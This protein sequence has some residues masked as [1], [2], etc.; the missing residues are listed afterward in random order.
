[1]KLVL[2]YAILTIVAVGFV[3][4]V[5]AELTAEIE[6]YSINKTV[7]IPH[8]VIDEACETFLDGFQPLTQCYFAG[9]LYNSTEFLPNLVWDHV[10]EEYKTPEQLE[11]EAREIYE[12]GDYSITLED[13]ANGF[14][15]YVE[16]LSAS[17]SELERLINNMLGAK[18]HQ[19]IGTTNGIQNVRSFDIPTITI[20][21]YEEIDGEMVDTGRTRE[22]LDTTRTIKDVNLRSVLGELIKD[23]RECAAQTILLDPHGGVLSITDLNFGYCDS[24]DIEDTTQLAVCGK[25]YSHATNA[26]NVPVWS[27]A[28]VNEESNPDTLDQPSYN[29]D[30]IC[31]GYYSLSYKQSVGCP[32]EYFSTVPSSKTMKDYHDSDVGQRYDQYLEDGGQQAAE[33]ARKKAIQ[34]KI[35]QLSKQLRAWT[36]P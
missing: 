26:A 9:N 7:T 35:A 3:S 20:P 23:A 19:G 2:T 14:E 29:T 15:D 22:V 6:V 16:T 12:N 18:C 33:D 5:D 31:D 17:E 28:R 21:V 24:I 27:Q 30:F 10:D 11:A 1:M 32:E 36:N 13:E 8:P 34:D 4:F 25:T